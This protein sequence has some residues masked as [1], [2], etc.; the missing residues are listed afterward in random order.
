MVAGPAQDEARASVGSIGAKVLDISLGLIYLVVNTNFRH[1]MERAI[2]ASDAN[3][4][5]SEMLRD[6]QRG[7]QF[8]VMS[9]GRPVARILPVAVTPSNKSVEVLVDF[10]R[11]LPERHAAD[12]QRAD[13]YG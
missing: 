5:F 13:L 9:R 4:H 12:W 11:R 6:V 10:L 1:V 8:V 3:Q 2:S 7:E